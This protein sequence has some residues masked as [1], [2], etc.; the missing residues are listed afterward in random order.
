[1]EVSG[2]RQDAVLVISV[3]REL[4]CRPSFRGR[5]LAGSRD[6]ELPEGRPVRS[7]AEILDAVAEWLRRRMPED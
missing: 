4:D 7:H 1:M 2:D 3:W 5:V 6:D